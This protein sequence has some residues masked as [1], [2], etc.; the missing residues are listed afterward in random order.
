MKKESA[1]VEEQKWTAAG[2]IMGTVRSNPQL[3][4]AHQLDIKTAVD[5][6][7]ESRFGPR[8][9]QAAAPKSSPSGTQKV[10]AFH[11]SMICPL[12]LSLS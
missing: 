1:K 6:A 5:E 9:K 11:L 8:S 2:P 12:T 10:G 7:F 4:W 3:R